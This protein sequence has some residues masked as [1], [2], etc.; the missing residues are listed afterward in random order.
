M[1]IRL[2]LPL[3]G[4]LLAPSFFLPGVALSADCAV[5]VA[6]AGAC[7]VPANVFKVTV[8]A[9]GGGG[10]GGAGTGI[11]NS[12]GG[13]G[14]GSFC[15]NLDVP[16]QPGDELTITVGDG[17]NS[18]SGNGGVSSVVDGVESLVSAAGGT[19]VGS[20][21]TGGAGGAAC[22][23]AGATGYAGGRGGNGAGGGGGGGGGAG[24]GGSGGDGGDGG[25]L[26]TNGTGGTGGTGETAGGAG[27]R[28][29]Y[30]AIA[31]VAGSA[32]GGGGGGRS[33][34]NNSRAD[35]A[36]GQVTL[37]FT[38]SEPN[39]ALSGITVDDGPGPV[40]VPADGIS[41]ATIA[42]TVVDGDENPL[43]GSVVLSASSATTV[44]LPSATQPLIQGV[45][46]FTVT[47]TVVE[48]VTYTA[49][50][51]TDPDQPP[52][53]GF[54]PAAIST[55]GNVVVNFD[56]PP[57]P[58]ATSIPTMSAYGLLAMTGL[59]GLLAG[60]HQRRRRG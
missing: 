51:Y 19:G 9:W 23:I 35:G 12:G 25:L 16:V 24:S 13:G 20:S 11:I 46:T 21:A 54:A 31:A 37:A 1:R 10:R 3:T 58:V 14:G 28:G 22:T 44:I 48:S 39:G 17:G 18:A 42:V 34:L 41:S 57:P 33:T 26:P 60:W 6:A 2:A 43:S 32:P 45:A 4:L 40:N 55:I 15:G 53:N 27:G 56:A 47:N 49:V 52:V 30:T 36:A 59:L 38:V 29:A 7:T 8:E 5:G 50:A